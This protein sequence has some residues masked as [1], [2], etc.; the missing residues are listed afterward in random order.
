MHVI[1]RNECT[2]VASLICSKFI[3]I[4]NIDVNINPQVTYNSIEYIRHVVKN[5]IK[6]YNAKY[7]TNFIIF[8]IKKIKSRQ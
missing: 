5:K 3:T 7:I 6:K 1:I 4:N 8:F 2:T